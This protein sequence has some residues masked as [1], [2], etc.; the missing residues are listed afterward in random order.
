MKRIFTRTALVTMGDC[1]DKKL[2]SF[3]RES[4][5]SIRRPGYDYWLRIDDE[6]ERKL[7]EVLS[8]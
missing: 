5:F 2:A 6:L 4:R 3:E 1:L 8:D 7:N